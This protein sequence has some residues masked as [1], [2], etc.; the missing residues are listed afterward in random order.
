MTRFLAGVESSTHCIVRDRAYLDGLCTMLANQSQVGETRVIYTTWRFSE[1]QSESSATHTLFFN[2]D[3]R[4]ILNYF[5][6]FLNNTRWSPS[7]ISK[8]IIIISVAV[9]TLFD[10]EELNHTVTSTALPKKIYFQ[11]PVNDDYSK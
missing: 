9:R 11:A 5:Y 4:N 10:F 1:Y 2:T 6:K 3:Y 8:N 7:W